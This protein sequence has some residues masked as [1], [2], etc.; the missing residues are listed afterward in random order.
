MEVV[1]YQIFIA[2]TIT[3]TH[4][5]KREGVLILCGFWSLLTIVNLFFPPLIVIQLCVIWGTYF[6]LNNNYRKNKKVSEFEELITRALPAELKEKIKT[7]SSEDKR[8]LSGIEH[9]SY[10]RKQI[11]SAT[12]SVAILSGWLSA[13]VVDKE[14][15]NLL[16]SKL[17]EGIHFHIGYGWQD[18]QGVHST[19]NESKKALDSLTCARKFPPYS[20]RV[21]TTEGDYYEAI[22]FQ[23]RTD[24]CDIKRA[25]EW[26]ADEG[27]VPQAWHQHGNIL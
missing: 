25:G 12:Q 17:K 18:S 8:I 16:R 6:L 14:F 24:Y 22:P 10:M 21:S 1:Y 11:Q 2:A 7:I 20:V 26:L 27:C 5:L 23:R 9:Y 13:R 4:F 3:A 15:V 19:G